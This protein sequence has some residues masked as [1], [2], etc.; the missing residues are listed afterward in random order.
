MI[1]LIE[2]GVRKPEHT[3]ECLKR[4]S[5]PKPAWLPSL[6]GNKLIFYSPFREVISRFHK[7]KEG[8]KTFESHRQMAEDFLG[9]MGGKKHI[10][11]D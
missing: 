10:F 11:M 7:N 9:G 6:R 5:C 4:G 3:R 2:M 8:L 1:L